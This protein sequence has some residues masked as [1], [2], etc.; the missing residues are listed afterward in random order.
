MKYF[1][2]C[3]FKF[4][5]C[6]FKMPSATQVNRSVDNLK[7][8]WSTISVDK[9]KCKENIL[10][11]FGTLGLLN[12]FRHILALVIIFFP[13]YLLDKT[14]ELVDLPIQM[15]FRNHFEKAFPKCF[16]S[17]LEHCLDFNLTRLEKS[18]IHLLATNQVKTEFLL[19]QS[20]V[21]PSE[22]TISLTKSK[23]LI[24]NLFTENENSEDFENTIEIENTQNH[25]NMQVLHPDLPK[26]FTPLCLPGLTHNFGDLEV[27]A[28]NIFD[29]EGNLIG[30]KKLKWVGGNSL[31][32]GQIKND[33]KYLKYSR[34]IQPREEI[35]P[36][37]I[38]TCG[39]EGTRETPCYG[40]YLAGTFPFLFIFSLALMFGNEGTK[41]F[42]YKNFTKLKR[43]DI[44][45]ANDD[46]HP[47]FQT[48]SS[49][50]NRRCYYLVASI[51]EHPFESHLHFCV[52]NLTGPGLSRQNYTN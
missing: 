17:W 27:D 18:I 49:E 25:Q 8:K 2:H 37:I 42:I 28:H 52:Q 3:N 51:E 14:K 24:Q 34:L 41:N 35:F 48:V 33:L 1:I 13:L 45:C 38:E 32:Y 19:K 26:E 43:I 29:R 44:K 9:S 47:N 5:V 12:K 23:K 10:N 6:Y 4:L 16:S 46:Q 21:K 39:H 31:N 11:N 36:D 15:Q 22:F 40:T 30:P 7:K 50:T 20:Y